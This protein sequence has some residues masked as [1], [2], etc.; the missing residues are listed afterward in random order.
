ML[1]DYARSPHLYLALLL[2]DG[3]NKDFPKDPITAKIHDSRT[4]DPLLAVAWRDGQHIYFIT[5][6]H[7]AELPK[8]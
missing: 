1:C 8:S 7:R 6:M 5:T 4:N 2:W 3:T